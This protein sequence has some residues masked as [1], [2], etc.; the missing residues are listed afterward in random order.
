MKKILLIIVCLISFAT[1]YEQNNI[2][3]S[4]ATFGTNVATFMKDFCKGEDSK[5]YRSKSDEIYN[6]DICNGYW[7]STF[8]NSEKW[9]FW[10]F[11]SRE[12]NTAFRTICTHSHSSD[13]QGNVM[14]LVKVLEEK[15][16]GHREENKSDLGYIHDGSNK[17]KEMFALYYYIKNASNKVIGEVRISCAPRGNGGLV[18]LSYR[19][20]AANDKAKIEYHNIVNNTF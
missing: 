1:I 4:G 7:G 16:G 8:I 5:Y 2:R 20:V 10:A 6:S 13:L 14:L 15:Y 18:E 11:S 12:T 9:Y 19:D 3:F 17:F